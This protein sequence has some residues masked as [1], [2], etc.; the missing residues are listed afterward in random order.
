MTPFKDLRI[1]A[2]LGLGFGSVLALAALTLARLGWRDALR[3]DPYLRAG[4]NVALGQ[5]T[6]AAVAAQHGL[7]Y[8]PAEQLIG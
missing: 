4:L 3:A 6:Y 2:R 1:A 7:P 5:V 8:V